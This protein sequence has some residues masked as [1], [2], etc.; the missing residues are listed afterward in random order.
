M[1]QNDKWGAEHLSI[2]YESYKLLCRS[3]NKIDLKTFRGWSHWKAWKFLYMP[4]SKMIQLLN[5]QSNFS[6]AKSSFF[7][8]ILIPSCLLNILSIIF[9]FS[10][11][12]PLPCMAKYPHSQDCSLAHASCYSPSEVPIP[13]FHKTKL[14]QS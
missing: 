9:H 5:F 10:H 3:K 2:N 4:L 14:V 6:K 8:R 13:S 1:S 12:L 7:T 11:Y